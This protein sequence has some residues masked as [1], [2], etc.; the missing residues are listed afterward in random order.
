MGLSSYLFPSRQCS[1]Y[2]PA[3]PERGSLSLNVINQG[4]VGLL[5]GKTGSLQVQEEV[6]N[7]A[8]QIWMAI[9]GLQ[10]IA[11]VSTAEVQLIAI[12]Y[13]SIHY[14]LV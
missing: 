8:E 12:T 7:M 10:V 5:L 1:K 2:G 14:E 4:T 3:K 11:L 6:P 13:K 9:W